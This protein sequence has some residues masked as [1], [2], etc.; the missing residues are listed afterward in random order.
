[1]KVELLW[2]PG[3]PNWQETDQRLREALALSG[4]DAEVALVEVSTPEDAERLRFRGSPTVGLSCRV[5]GTPDGLRGAP[6]VE[7][8]VDALRGAA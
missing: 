8:L 2:F 1:V 5:F 6:T 3:C 7:Q 4:T